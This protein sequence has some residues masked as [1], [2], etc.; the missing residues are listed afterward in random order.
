MLLRSSRRIARGEWITRADIFDVPAEV[1]IAQFRIVLCVLAV[2]AVYVDSQPSRFTALAGV[3]V[4]T[5]S[6]IS[7]AFLAI[8]LVKPPGPTAGYFIHIADMVFLMTTFALVT[9]GRPSPLVSVFA[10][11]VLIA[12]ALRWNWEGVAA[13][14]AAYAL[15]MLGVGL[16]QSTGARPV[17]WEYF[18]RSVV[19][20]AY[21]FVAGG[22]LVYFTGLR[23]RR[24]SQLT[25]L[26]SGPALE[27]SHPHFPSV[28][29]VLGH[30]ALVLEVQRVLVLWEETDEPALCVAFWRNDGYELTRKAPGTFGDLVAPGSELT[31][32]FLAD[33]PQSGWILSKAGWRRVQ[34]PVLDAELIRTFDIRSFA[35]AP[36][37]GGFCKGQVFL[38]ERGSWSE[39]QLLLTEHVAS[40]IALELDRRILERQTEE[41]TTARE[42][43]RLTRDLHDGILQSLTAANLQVKL[44][45]EGNPGDI[46]ARLDTIRQLLS[47]E[48]VRIRDFVTQALPK[49]A[50]AKPALATEMALGRDLRQ[51]LTEAG[52]QWD[53]ATS[54][55]L[56]PEEA[57]V[58]SGLGYH[59]AFIM[60]EAVANAARHGGAANVNVQIHVTEREIAVR[61]K[62]DGRGIGATPQRYNHNE[63]AA[64]GLGPVSLR[65]RVVG[66]RGALELSSSAAGTEIG[67][68]VPLS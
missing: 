29:T 59:L 22:M 66:L 17:N 10:F 52:R 44:L 36:F 43:S 13:T 46:R 41:A 45:S 33:N 65:E 28:A 3:V 14:A 64:L 60:R 37:V 1:V 9:E 19:R 35:T 12:A 68:R 40:R 48:Q 7:V 51:V 54:L 58:S 57:I 11:F 62:D 25:R 34:G 15:V 23:E 26:A 16:L 63:L 5:Y 2:F 55:S 21:V 53:C 49:P 67:I 4:I 20:C 39:F 61:I 50:S 18:E 32:P 31:A 6:V 47:N 27:P 8:A 30:C 24:R 38:L 42:R 56:E